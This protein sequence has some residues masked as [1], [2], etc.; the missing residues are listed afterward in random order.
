MHEAVRAGK[1]ALTAAVHR[2]AREGASTER[3]AGGGANLRMPLSMRG[4]Q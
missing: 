1:P 3:L 4:T 2:R